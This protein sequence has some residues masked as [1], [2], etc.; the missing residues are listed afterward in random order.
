MLKFVVVLLGGSSVV[1]QLVIVI[2][3]VKDGLGVVQKTLVTGDVPSNK[4]K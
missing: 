3:M 2:T 1:V 4:H